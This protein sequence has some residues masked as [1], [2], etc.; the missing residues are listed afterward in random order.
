MPLKQYVRCALKHV[1]PTPAIRPELGRY[2]F[3]GKVRNPGN[4]Q[5]FSLRASAEDT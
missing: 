4:P 2:E 5:A 3:P 1:P